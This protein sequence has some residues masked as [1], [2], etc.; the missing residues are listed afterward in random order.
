MLHSNYMTELYHLREEWK[1]ALKDL[2][3]RKKDQYRREA[4]IWGLITGYQLS[5]ADKDRYDVEK[6][7]IDSYYRS[8]ISKLEEYYRNQFNIIVK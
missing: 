5:E 1:A 6:T 8:E 7:D 3:T 4:G 2:E